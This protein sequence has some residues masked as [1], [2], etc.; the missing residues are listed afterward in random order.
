MSIYCV[1]DVFALIHPSLKMLKVALMITKTERAHLNILSVYLN[2]NTSEYLSTETPIK[3]TAHP[4]VNVNLLIACNSI[5]RS[6][7]HSSCDIS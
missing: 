2:D 6:F 5:R 3:K 4:F 7:K 1:E